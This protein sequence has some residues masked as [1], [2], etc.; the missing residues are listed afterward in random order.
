MHWTIAA[1][2]IDNESIDKDWLVPY[3]QGNHEF[4]VIP[5]S[6]PLAN[7]HNQKLP[8]TGYRQWLKYLEQ[9]KEAV[10]TSRGGVITVFPQLAAAVGVHQKLARKR[11]PTVAWLFNVGV[12]Y[13]GYR[14]WLAKASV[15]NID[16]FVMHSRR[17]CQLYSDWLGLPKDRFVFV[18]YQSPEIPVTYEENTTEPFI[19]AIGSAHRDFPTLFKAVEKLNIPTILASGPRALAGLTL[20]PQVK[21]PLGIGKKECLQLAQEARINVVPLLPNE[22]VTAAGQVTIVEAMRMGRAIVAT[23]C[24]GAEDYIEHGKTGLLVDP[25]S[26]KD[27]TDAIAMLWNDAELRQR[28]GQA[29]QAFATENFSDEAAGRALGQILDR[30][31]ADYA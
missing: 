12:C 27:L 2:F 29:A 21:A 20:P 24:N 11:Q 28:L 18:P 14:R 3:I 31:A 8:V 4:T 25:C 19:V 9:A 26:E 23:R 15:S 17:E 5:R 10:N 6:E 13:P 30:L 7:W 22:K 1:P 16:C